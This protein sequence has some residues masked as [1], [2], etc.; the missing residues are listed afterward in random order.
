MRLVESVSCVM[1]C[2][3]E[4][5]KESKANNQLMVTSPCRELDDE[6]SI[7]VRQDIRS[8]G[9]LK[10]CTEEAPSTVNKQ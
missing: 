2:T 10:Y 4:A 6:R 9:C 1:N 8:L 7:W 5:G 3:L